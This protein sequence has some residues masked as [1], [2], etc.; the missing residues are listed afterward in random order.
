MVY[1]LKLYCKLGKPLTEPSEYNRVSAW[2]G[3][4]KAYYL[5]LVFELCKAKNLSSAVYEKDGKFAVFAEL[6]YFT[7]EEFVKFLSIY[8]KE[9]KYVV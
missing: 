1:N 8:Y 6:T 2:V 4:E 7:W 5:Y 9:F 3:L